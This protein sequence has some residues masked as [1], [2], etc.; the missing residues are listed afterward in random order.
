MTIY[1]H[2]GEYDV[3]KEEKNAPARNGR[4]QTPELGEKKPLP[5]NCHRQQIEQIGNQTSPNKSIFRFNVWGKLKPHPI[6][7]H[8]I[9]PYDEDDP[10]IEM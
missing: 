5:G 2:F 9:I 6:G 4:Q 8:L 7:H 10:K 3:K 1:D